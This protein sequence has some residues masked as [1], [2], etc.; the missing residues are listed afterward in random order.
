MRT[1][2]FE[3][4]APSYTGLAIQF[5]AEGAHHRILSIT[6]TDMAGKELFE[7][8][9]GGFGGVVDFRD[10][11]FVFNNVFL[12]FHGNGVEVRGIHL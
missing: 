11:F 4:Q 7:L 3:M 1:L 5:R 12:L 10:Y 6:K 8:L 2:R 9:A